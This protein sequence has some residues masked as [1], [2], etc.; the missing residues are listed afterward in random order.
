[1]VIRWQVTEGSGRL[2]V[3]AVGEHSEWGRT[4]ALVAS[5]PAP[6][7]L[8]AS[9]GTLAAAIGKV[10]LVVGA[11]CFVVLLVRWAAH[12]RFT[13]LHTD[14]P[15][16]DWSRLIWDTL[17]QAESR[18]PHSVCRTAT[19]R[20][21]TASSCH[22]WACSTFSWTWMGVSAPGCRGRTAG[23]GGWEAVR[24]GHVGGRWCIYE[25]GFPLSKIVEGPLQFFIFGV[26]I[27]V[28][29]VPEGLPLAVTISLAYRCPLVL[30]HP[31]PASMDGRMMNGYCS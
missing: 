15:N 1:M 19:K 9:L 20:K 7:P 23:E 17:T 2:L 14:R 21:G 16:S 30:F 18:L 27:V 31:I 29:A 6:T 13:E 4:M 24:Q 25:R 5:E 28:V 12:R 3:L 22:G 26:T 11:L 8:Q 10:G